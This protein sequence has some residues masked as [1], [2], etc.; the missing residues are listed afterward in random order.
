M[1]SLSYDDDFENSL[2]QEF[3]SIERRSPKKLTRKGNRHSV[4]KPMGRAG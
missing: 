2:V 1:D 4:L 3:S